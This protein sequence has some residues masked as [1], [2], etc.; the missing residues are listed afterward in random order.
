VKRGSARVASLAV[1]CLIASSCG[2]FQLTRSGP[3]PSFDPSSAIALSVLADS[4]YLIDPATGQMQT[5]ATGLTDFQSGYAAWAPDHRHLAWGDG[6]ITIL[7]VATGTKRQ[8]TRGQS[9]SMPAWSPGGD[10]IVYGDGTGLWVT[11][12]A[13]V[14]PV[15]LSVP[16]TLSPI[17]MAWSP[18]STI[19]FE[20]V[21]LDCE[22]GA[23]CMSSE[24]SEIYTIRPDGSHLKRLTRVVHAENPR[25]SPDGT[26]ILFIR[27]VVTAKGQRSEL[28]VMNADGTGAK[29][30]GSDNDVM[31]A[32]WS[33]TG[34]QIAL[35]RPGPVGSIL[36]VW[37]A[38]ADGS[39]EQPLGPA[40]GGTDATID[41]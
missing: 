41:W 12:L 15:Q 36:Q 35:V 21:H 9:L 14:R 6:G 34:R 38:N 22:N 32:A 1:L 37:V 2:R 31:A 29:R 8:I 20:G 7:N 39:N 26:Q 24:L 13:R 33:P 17:G 28:W 30:L 40:V 19:T 18:S 10:Q 27:L 4:I 5:V 3:I 25:W 23:A 11:K 16:S